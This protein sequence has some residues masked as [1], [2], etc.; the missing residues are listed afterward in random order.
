MF[1]KILV[2]YLLVCVFMCKETSASKRHDETG[3]EKTQQE[4]NKYK[5]KNYNFFKLLSTF[6]SLPLFKSFF[7]N[8]IL[9]R[10][11]SQPLSYNPI[12]KIVIRC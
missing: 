5:R 1:K 8:N 9:N 11:F 3:I 7:M 10:Y 4:E 6:N 2:F 12:F